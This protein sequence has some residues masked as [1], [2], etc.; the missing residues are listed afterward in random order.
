MPP[1]SIGETSAT[2]H[3]AAALA[4]LGLNANTFLA[5]DAHGDWAKGPNAPRRSVDRL[6]G[7][8]PSENARYA[9]SES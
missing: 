6:T 1:V 8:P 4:A 9:S 3:L 7:G 5:C 2:A